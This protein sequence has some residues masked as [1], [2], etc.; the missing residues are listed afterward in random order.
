[1]Q[2]PLSFSSRSPAKTYTPCSIEFFSLTYYGF[3]VNTERK[4]IRDRIYTGVQLLLSDPAS[5]YETN[6]KCGYFCQE[7]DQNPSS[8]SKINQM[9]ECLVA[10]DVHTAKKRWDESIALHSENQGLKNYY[11]VNLAP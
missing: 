6:P 9:M 11:Q 3:K 7:S 5:P 2:Y 1:M 4:T 10:E 8:S